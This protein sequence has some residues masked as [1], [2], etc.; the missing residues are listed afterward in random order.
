VRVFA[1]E[2]ARNAEFVNLSRGTLSLP[3]PMQQANW[4]ALSGG[5]KVL[6]RSA[7]GSM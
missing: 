1:D 6:L 2:A 5:V 7:E 3:V 4:Y